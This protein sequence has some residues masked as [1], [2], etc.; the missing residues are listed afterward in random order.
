V[1]ARYILPYVA[2]RKKVLVDVV[3]A[4]SLGGKARAQNLSD[5][6]LSDQGR[7][8]VRARWDAYY[9]AHPEKLKAK[10]DRET[11]RRKRKKE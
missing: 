7:N 4:G 8:A 9:Q 10:L 6:E 5:G 3:K 2:A 11:K 1:V